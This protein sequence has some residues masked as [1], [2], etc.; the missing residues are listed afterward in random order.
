RPDRAGEPAEHCRHT[1]PVDQVR[2]LSHRLSQGPRHRDARRSARPVRGA[3]STLA[4]AIDVPADGLCPPLGDDG[5]RNAPCVAYFGHVG[6]GALIGSPITAETGM[7]LNQRVRAPL[8]AVTRFLHD[9]RGAAAAIVAVMIPVLI[10]FE[11][12]GVETG[13]WHMIKRQTQSAAHA[14][15]IAT[16]HERIAG[17][18]DA[19]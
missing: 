7:A 3:G 2:H 5:D 10:G 17:K 18:T 14:A 8:D 6:A 4:R 11:T 13:L 1:Q 19:T 16:A 12:L 9:N 15:A